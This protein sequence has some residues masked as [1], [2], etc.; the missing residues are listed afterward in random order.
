MRLHLKE[1]TTAFAIL[2]LGAGT[3]AA[4]NSMD[5]AAWN[6]EDLTGTWRATEMTDTPVYGETGEDIGEV[7]NL[8]VGPDNKVQ[9]I[10]VE[11]GGLFDIGDTHFSVPWDQVDVTP[12]EEG[13]RVPV[14][15]ENV[16]DFDLF[17]WDEVE[18][19]QRSWRVTE[20]LGDN[21][22]FS[23]DSGY[24]IVYDLLFEQDGTLKSVVVNPSVGYGVGGYFAYPWR[25]YQEEG[26]DPGDPFYNVGY[27]RDDVAGLEPVDLDAIET[28]LF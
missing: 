28:D 7:A 4:Q 8:I 3:A 15:E 27:D 22:M 2:A 10:V 24:G 12:G 14:N 18:D 11:A 25:G 1:T 19:G 17:S 23:D 16:A 21:V 20:L 13:I 26:F 5:L 9:A 6:D